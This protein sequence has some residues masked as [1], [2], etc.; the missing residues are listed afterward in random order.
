MK[1]K[2]LL[3]IFFSFYFVSCSSLFNSFSGK[4]FEKKELTFHYGFIIADSSGQILKSGNEQRLFTPASVLKLYHLPYFLNLKND[5]SYLTTGFSVKQK[6]DSLQISIY[7]NGDPLLKSHE[8]DSIASL[9]KK[10]S[11]PVSTVTIYT[12]KYDTSEFWGT[13]W[14]WDDEP[15][16]YQSYLNRF[17]VDENCIGVVYNRINSTDYISF[18][19][20]KLPV[21]FSNGSLQIK[22]N[23]TENEI[24]ISRPDSLTQSKQ[25]KKIFS[26]RNPD[27]VIAG[28]I[29]EKFQT[30]S[31]NF[32]Y[33]DSSEKP[34]FN[35]SIVHPFDSLMTRILTY[36]SNF[37]AEQSIRFSAIKNGLPGNIKNGLSIEKQSNSQFQNRV[38]DGSGLSRY[39]L[40]SPESVFKKISKDS[41]FNKKWFALYAKKGTLRDRIEL[42]NKSITIYAKSG[43]M[44][45]VQNLAGF[46][47]KNNKLVGYAL[48]FT[49]N[50]VENKETRNRFEK[51]FLDYAVEILE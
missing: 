26:F 10:D 16:D 47:F 19:G 11:I 6:N 13:G 20:I 37:C 8:L 48:L 5:S 49:N 12:A 36:S 28:F 15:D 41:E 50:T 32:Q 27:S 30:N 17:P 51:E 7:S 31:V 39:N 4:T 18:D 25:V 46:I 29:S 42:K 23:R 35:Y 9:I 40:I 22:R 33:S 34:A 3:L 44:T 2:I 14:M 43:T 38:V 24:L 1:P 45:G 21:I